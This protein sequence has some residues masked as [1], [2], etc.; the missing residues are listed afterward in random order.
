MILLYCHRH[1][2]QSQNL[3]SWAETTSSDLLSLNATI[4]PDYWWFVPLCQGVNCA[5]MRGT[6]VWAFHQCSSVTNHLPG[7][8]VKQPRELRLSG[9]LWPPHGQRAASSREGHS[10]G[11][12]RKPTHQ[13]AHLQRPSPITCPVQSQPWEQLKWENGVSQETRALVYLGF[14]EQ[15]P[16]PG[17]SALWSGEFGPV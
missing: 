10:P 3:K 6:V 17:A 9:P 13:A 14:A 5:R 7:R 12:Y 15:T 4:K 2:P 11:T 16:K 8:S 1:C